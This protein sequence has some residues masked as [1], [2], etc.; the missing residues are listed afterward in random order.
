MQH[1]DSGGQ[2]EEQRDRRRP[3]PV[4]PPAYPHRP[5][6]E[7][8]G[9][10]RCLGR[11]L[12]RGAVA[13]ARLLLEALCHPLALA[14]RLARFL[15][16][17]GLVAAH[18]VHAEVVLGNADVVG[19]RLGVLGGKRLARLARPLLRQLR[20]RPHRPP[21][22]PDLSGEGAGRKIPPPLTMEGC[23][24]WSKSALSARSSARK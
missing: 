12:G 15:G 22:G 13:L 8:L 11:R 9:L 16:H 5:H 20:P 24:T 6:L 19:A 3:A 18:V 17:R 4:A 2:D 7:R 14:T 1:A 10:G 21:H 23:L